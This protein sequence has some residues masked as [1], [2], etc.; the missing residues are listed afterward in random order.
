MKN[1]PK[2]ASSTR[3]MG[4]IQSKRSRVVTLKKLLRSMLREA[5]SI[6]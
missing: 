3:Q 2:V 1:T 6:R 4:V 5:F